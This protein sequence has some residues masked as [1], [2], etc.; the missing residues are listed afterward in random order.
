M[1]RRIKKPRWHPTVHGGADKYKVEIEFQ[2]Y[3]DENEQFTI[4]NDHGK[5]N[6]STQFSL[7]I[8]L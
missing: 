7:S 1:T 3:N 4:F 6:F 5:F 2:R 8:P